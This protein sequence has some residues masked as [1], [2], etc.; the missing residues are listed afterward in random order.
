[1]EEQAE[2]WEENFD[3]YKS[4]DNGDSFDEYYN[5]PVETDARNSGRDYLNNLT[6][7]EFNRLLEESR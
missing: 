5:Q 4:T 7:E 3:E 6:E 2:E 1:S